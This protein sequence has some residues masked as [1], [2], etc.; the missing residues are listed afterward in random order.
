[1]H[2]MLCC[3]VA[4]VAV[5]PGL[6][7]PCS[8]LHSGG[9]APPAS[10]FAAS[11][12][13]ACSSS[14]CST[15]GGGAV[16]GGI[17]AEGCTSFGHLFQCDVF[18]AAPPPPPPAAEEKLGGAPLTPAQHHVSPTASQA[19]LFLEVQPHDMTQHDMMYVLLINWSALCV[20]C[21][22]VYLRC[23]CAHVCVCVMLLLLA[24]GVLGQLPRAPHAGGLRLHAPAPAPLLLLLLP[25]AQ[26]RRGRQHVE[27]HR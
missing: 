14:S 25:L 5:L 1:M 17:V 23:V 19:T 2:A 27:A 11:R 10:D 7:S 24:P 4:Q 9:P 20:M 26:H 13:P 15:S 21:R 22:C 12:G 18:V 6:G 3:A 8:R 16:L